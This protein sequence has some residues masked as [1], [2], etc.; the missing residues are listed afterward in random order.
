MYTMVIADDEYIVRN[1]LISV[2][3]WNELGIE[4]IGEAVNGEEALKLCL[5]LKPDILFTDIRMPL[6]DGLEVAAC[7][8]EQNNEIKII[9]I[10]G[11]EDFNYAKT[12]LDIK[13]EGYILKPVDIDE[14]LGVVKKVINI[15]QL[16]RNRE[17][18][19]NQLQIQLKENLPI[20]RDKFLYNVIK[21]TYNNNFKLQERM[22]YLN[23]PFEVSESF[24]V[25]VLRVDEYTKDSQFNNEESLHIVDFSI[26]NIVSELLSTQNA[27]V[28][29]N[30][31]QNEFFIVFNQTSIL[32]EIY[33]EIC[34][35]IL[36]VI[37]KFLLVS[38]SIGVGKIVEGFE[39]LSVSY[40]QA[41]TAI[42]HRFYTGRNAIINITDIEAGNPSNSVNE[43]DL[44]NIESQIVNAVKLGNT[45][46]VMDN[47]NL[48]FKHIT[49]ETKPPVEYVQM[50]YA[51]LITLMARTLYESNEN[52]EKI[53][54][55]TS[56]IIANVFKMKDIFALNQFVNRVFLQL[57]ENFSEK[58][59]Q[60]KDKT[61]YHIKEIIQNRY[62]DNISVSSIAKEIYLT[63]NYISQIF[64][65]YTG[66]TLTEYI[67]YIRMEQAKKLL[68]TT[69]L[70]I[71]DIAERVG[72]QNTN[73]F[74]T[75][76]KK[77]TNVYPQKYRTD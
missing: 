18:K 69:D 45:S 23:L 9:I 52:M 40:K 55:P 53:V 4:I 71:L 30:A 39:H 41:A 10:S 11:I 74:S 13:A 22:K 26:L 17:S 37:Q 54:G 35:E 57:A 33:V 60:L 75:V 72:Y 6:M 70:K 29:I 56:N 61:I 36:A 49:I 62:M 73:Y 66:Q 14:L 12:A 27:G 46:Q 21:G 65:Q 77:Y 63:P 50:I 64:K 76:F 20:A 2:I 15:I 68:K 32:N 51:E 38:C 16:E 7:L 5:E 59:L 34:E 47:L 1:G 43:S 3:D 58:Y 44:F 31:E 25:G 8:K 19:L 24:V 67:T 28:C 42:E 48:I